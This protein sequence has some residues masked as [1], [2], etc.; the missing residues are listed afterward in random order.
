[1]YLALGEGAQ[2][3]SQTVWIKFLNYLY[4]ADAMKANIDTF[5]GGH[6]L[7]TWV[8]VTHCEVI[9]NG[10]SIVLVNPNT[11]SSDWVSNGNANNVEAQ[12]VITTAFETNEFDAMP[13]VDVIGH[14]DD[15]VATFPKGVMGQ[16]NPNYVPD[17][18]GQRF[19]LTQHARHKGPDFCA[20]KHGE[21]WHTATSAM[22]LDT[23]QSSIS[24]AD[25]L[26][27]N[28][29]ALYFYHAIA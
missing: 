8:P 22:A 29:V 4:K 19:D 27:P 5:A 12:I 3:S 17:G 2:F 15:I 11:G 1:M 26:Q 21:Q 13:Y 20:Y 6:S 7:N 9:D 25:I 24:S 28:S 14:I 18:S 23:V 10:Q 16:V